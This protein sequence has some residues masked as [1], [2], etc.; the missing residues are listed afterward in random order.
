MVPFTLLAAVALGASV[1]REPHTFQQAELH[2]KRP[3]QVV[4][5]QGKSGS[6]KASWSL[7]FGHIGPSFFH[8][9][10]IKTSQKASSEYKG[11][12]NVCLPLMRGA[13]KSH[14]KGVWME[15]IHTSH[16]TVPDL[17]S[18]TGTCFIVQKLS[19]VFLS[20]TGIF[21]LFH[22]IYNYIFLYIFEGFWWLDFMRNTFMHY[23]LYIYVHNI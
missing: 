11:W 1:P 16:H 13:A 8:I 21:T 20:I 6:H 22:N 4:L 9:L 10:L 12:G 7:G 15:P 17:P 2:S 19:I 5:Q 3:P 14:C 23:T 18:F